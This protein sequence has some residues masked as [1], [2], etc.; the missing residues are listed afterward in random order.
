VETKLP[1]PAKSP[2]FSSFEA[3]ECRLGIF[4][5]MISKE[6]AVSLLWHLLSFPSTTPN[7]T[8]GR[9]QRV[10]CTFLSINLISAYLAAYFCEQ[11]QNSGR[12]LNP[13]NPNA[14]K[15]AS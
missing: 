7:Q 15:A 8:C 9:K 11:E 5:Q 10:G 3:R 13:T 1:S 14:R 4:K 6:A 2:L 12:I